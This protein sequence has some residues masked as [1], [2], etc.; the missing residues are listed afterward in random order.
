MSSKLYLKLDDSQ[1]GIITDLTIDNEK[2]Y[3]LD[4]LVD[5]FAAFLLSLQYME[6]DIRKYINT[7]MFPI[8][9]EKK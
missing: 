9:L 8:I 5:H 1:L 4:E 7:D 2:G 6:K 3:Q